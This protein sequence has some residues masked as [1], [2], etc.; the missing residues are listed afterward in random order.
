[1]L[2]PERV[3]STASSVQGFVDL[4]TGLCLLLLSL[5]SP[6]PISDQARTVKPTIGK[7]TAINLD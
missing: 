2:A 6:D 7:T 5:F 4:T 3:F 1:M